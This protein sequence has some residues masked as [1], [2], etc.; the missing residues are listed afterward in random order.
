MVVLVAAF[1]GCQQDAGTSLGVGFGV[2]MPEGDAQL[3]AHIRQGGG[4]KTPDGTSCFDRA[5][6]ETC[7][8]AS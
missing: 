1:A 8:A 3:A 5:D 7:T 4:I 6:K 2:V